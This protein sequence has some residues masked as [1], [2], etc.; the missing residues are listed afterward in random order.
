[1]RFRLLIRHIVLRSSAKIDLPLAETFLPPGKSLETN[2]AC[3]NH[4]GS[5]ASGLILDNLQA[6]ERDR[7]DSLAN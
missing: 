1:M 3:G 4:K 5:E 7:M 2:G 6:E